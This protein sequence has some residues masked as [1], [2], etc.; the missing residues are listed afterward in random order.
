MLKDSDHVVPISAVTTDA[1]NDA[2][3]TEATLQSAGLTGDMADKLITAINASRQQRPKR[4]AP[5]RKKD[6]DPIVLE[7]P[8]NHCHHCGK[9]G[10]SRTS[11]QGKPGC[12]QYQAIL[13]AN[14][15][16]KKI[17]EAKRKDGQN[18]AGNLTGWKAEVAAA[19]Y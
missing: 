16:K 14:G 19:R 7:F 10:H 12:R 3:I 4:D 15:G 18:K 13:K 11:F 1:Q 17:S 6:I 9:P 8:K 5:Q 2:T